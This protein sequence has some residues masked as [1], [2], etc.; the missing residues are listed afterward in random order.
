MLGGGVVAVLRRTGQA[1]QLPGR[2][3][4]TLHRPLAPVAHRR[5]TLPAT[6]V[7]RRRGA[8][9]RRAG[10]GRDRVRDQAR[11]GLAPAGSGPRGPD[12]PCGRHGGCRLRGYPGLSGRPGTPP[13][14]VCRPSQQSLWR[15]LA[16]GRRGGGRAAGAGGPPARAAPQGRHGAAGAIWAERAA[17]PTATPGAGRAAVH[18]AGGDRRG[19]GGAVD[20]HHRAGCGRGGQPTPGLP[21]ARA[22]RTRRSHRA[23]GVVDWRAGLR[24]VWWTGRVQAACA[25]PASACSKAIGLRSPRAECDRRRL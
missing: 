7:G 23:G 16:G 21:P 1:R 24:S 13:R 3:D 17:P 22:S 5:A 12:R 6:V 10:T 8:P 14:G 4:R 9:C 25:S 11:P 20:D 2:G 15:P 19:A 18:G